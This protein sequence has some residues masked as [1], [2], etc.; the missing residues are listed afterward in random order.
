MTFYARI[1]LMEYGSDRTWMV[2]GFCAFAINVAQG[3]TML[4]GAYISGQAMSD[5]QCKSN[6]SDVVN[7]AI[8]CTAVFSGIVAINA[9]AVYFVFLPSF[10]LQRRQLRNFK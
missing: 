1:S 10:A 3:F 2:I 5:A 7:F 9:L 8:A 4:W 6:A